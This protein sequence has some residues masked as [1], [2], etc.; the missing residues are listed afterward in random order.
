MDEQNLQPDRPTTPIRRK[1]S[2][3]QV[4]KEAYLPVII[5]GAA[6]LLIIIFIIGSI[7]RAVE[8]GQINKAAEQAAAESAAAEQ[9]RQAAEA[10][11]LLAQAEIMA[12]GY[13]YAGAVALLD[14]FSGDATQ[15]PDLGTKRDEYM[16]LNDTMVVWSDPSQIPNLSFQLLI[17]DS[18]RAFNDDVYADAFDRNFVTTAEFSAILQQLYDNGYMLVRMEDFIQTEIAEDGTITYAAKELRLPS[19][20]KPIMLTQTNVNYNQYLID[21]DGDM[22]ADKGGS[23]F[24]S[25]LVLSGNNITSEMV[26]AEG[27]TVTGQFDLVPILD[28]FIDQHPDFSFRG[29]KA[30][31]ALTG[32]NGLYGYRTDNQAREK[33]GEEAY[34]QAVASVKEITKHLTEDGYTL[35]CYTYQNMG[36]GES[37]VAEI[38][39][40]LSNWNAE[41]V[42]VLGGVDI[43]V[44]AL[45]SDISNEAGYTGDKYDTLHNAG[46]NYFLGF[47]PD[48]QPWTEFGAGYVRQG[49]I[50]VG[51]SALKNHPE[52]FNGMFDAA[53]VLD[54]TRKTDA[55]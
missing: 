36:Y 11:S 24:A 49:R 27:Q 28:A 26:D 30:M 7:V 51:G 22:V 14:S 43:L 42:P 2:K 1:R 16:Q 21:S 33:L 45:N 39:A 10:E 37:S 48:G 9:E 31:L 54:A 5:A 55:Q 13:D 32:Y 41:V 6:V 19:G 38:Q 35:A 20:K 18:S 25:K 23:G 8:K 40:D 3:M 4:F 47:C 50:L 44:Y 12:K 52:W 53:S 29:A 15:Y 34:R 46:F 17:A